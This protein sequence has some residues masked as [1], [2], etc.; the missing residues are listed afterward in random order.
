[1]LKPIIPYAKDARGKDRDGFVADHPHA[2]FVVQPFEAVETDSFQTLS[3]GGPAAG[4]TIAVAEICKRPGSNAFTSMVTI[5]RAGNNDVRINAKSVSK[6]HAYVMIVGEELRL[7]DAGSTYGTHLGGQQLKAREDKI[8]LSSGDVVR[9]GTISMTFYA[10]A[11][12]HAMLL[13]AGQKA[14]L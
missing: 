1:M 10:P 3:G 4:N 5:G 14:A 2:V 7:V 12:F 11:D 9:I 8:P 6:F 13:E